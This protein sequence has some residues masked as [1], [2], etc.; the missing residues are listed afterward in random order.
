[1]LHRLRSP[2]RR[3]LLVPA[4]AAALLGP[5][6][7]AS[8]AQAAVPDRWGFGFLHTPTPV[9]G[10][11]LDMSR[12]WGS[13][14]SVAP[15]QWATV[16]P[17]GVGRYR[18][19]FPLTA[20][21]GVAQVTAV[22]RQPQ[23]CQIADSQPV[24]TDQVIDVACF[25]PGGVPSPSRFAISYSASSGVMPPPGGYAHV[26]SDPA[27][28]PLQSYN[29]TGAA[30]PVTHLG[31][32]QYHV[33]LQ[34]VGAGG[35]DGNLQVTAEHIGA[36]RRCKV[37]SWAPV[38]TGHSV[39]VWCH[40]HTNTLAD[41]GFHLTYHRER[42]VTGGLNP[43]HQFAYLFSPLLGGASDFNSLGGANTIFPAGPALDRVHFDL[44]GIRETHVQVTAFGPTPDYCHLQEVWQL[45][46][47]TVI[48]RNVV[49]FNGAGTMTANPY[50]IT[51]TS[52]V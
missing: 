44:V 38:G 31:P 21:A 47:S 22:S 35:L 16:D 4:L 20:S 13:W 10:T 29:S 40:D 52:R 33:L 51:Y 45:S 3:A 11:I 7:V 43:P 48:V 18:V 30:N 41:T 49:C 1:M 17:I 9:P 46:G 14:K 25:L 24:G 42:A 19:T 5:S 34:G 6:L 37:A 8:P 50:S 32:G 27:G 28:V 2:L 12:Q 23:W 36:P 26:V 15:G 39:L